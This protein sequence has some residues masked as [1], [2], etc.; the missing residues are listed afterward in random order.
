[1]IFLEAL[2]FNFI[3]YDINKFYYLAR[4]C[5]VKDEKLIDKFDI[6]FGEYFESIEKIEIDDVIKFVQKEISLGN[7]IFWVCPLIEE[8]KRIDHTSAIKKFEYLKKLFPN[9]VLLLHGKTT[10]DEKEN[11]LN[12][13]LKN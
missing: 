11:I 4:T 5:L 8:S 3:Q 6:V 10:I 7:Q 2:E 1:M 9:H 13:F 12:S